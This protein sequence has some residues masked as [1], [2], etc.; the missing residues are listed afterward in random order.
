MAKIRLE[1]LEGEVWKAVELKVTQ[2]RRDNL[3]VKHDGVPYVFKD[4]KEGTKVLKLKD[5]KWVE[6]GRLT[7][8]HTI[9]I[10]EGKSY[11]E[12]VDEQYGIKR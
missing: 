4:T 7:R 2:S 11:S 12:Y 10:G 3:F 9:F 6:A 1:W 8:Y 5:G